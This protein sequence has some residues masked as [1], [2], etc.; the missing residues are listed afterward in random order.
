MDRQEGQEMVL[1][2]ILLV[3]LILL[4]ALAIDGARI[5]LARENVQNA[6]DAAALAGAVELRTSG[7]WESAVKAA[8]AYAESNGAQACRVEIDQF[9]VAVVASQTEKTYFA[10]FLG[11]EEFT[12]SATA[13]AEVQ[14]YVAATPT[15]VLY[16]TLSLTPTP[17]PT[18]K[19]CLI[20]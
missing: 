19:V 20:E 17:S 10:G 12:V 5:Y 6:A 16:P 9:K 7:S 15:L 8:Q 4:A 2:A 14:P 13:A 18:P 1:V 3:V 11:L